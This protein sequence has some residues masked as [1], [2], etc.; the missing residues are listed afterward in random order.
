MIEKPSLA[1]AEIKCIRLVILS[2]ITS[3][4]ERI[5][6]YI[7]IVYTL[8]TIINRPGWG[9]NSS[10]ANVRICSHVIAFYVYIYVYIC[11]TNYQSSNSSNRIRIDRLESSTLLANIQSHASFDSDPSSGII[12]RIFLIFDIIHETKK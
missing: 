12:T 2:W 11:R 10:A 9:T 6:L 8:I 4:A 3:E 1:E 7:A 5:G